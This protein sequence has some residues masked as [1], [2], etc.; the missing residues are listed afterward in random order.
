[1]DCDQVRNLLDAYVDDEL[2][3]ATS[4]EIERHLDDCAGC[5]ERL[6]N[7]RALKQ[8]LQAD[9]LYYRAPDA[10][11][12]RVQ[13]ALPGTPASR[14]TG[15]TDRLRQNVWVSMA[16]ALI[17]GVLLSTALF[18]TPLLRISPSNGLAQ[19]VVDSHIRSLMANHLSDVVSTDQ[20]TVKPWFDGK[21]DFSPT[22]INLEAQGFPLIGG[23]LD[24]LD[25]RPVTA[26]VYQRQKHIINLFI[27]PEANASA[28]AS[29]PL[30][31]QGYHAISWI[32]DGTIYWAVSD[33]ELGE[34]QMF[35][36]LIRAQLPPS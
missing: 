18:Q 30:T 4:L 28:A 25:D 5:A 19:E 6:Q 10:L 12:Q 17:L 24:Y 36:Q 23:R 33:L 8:G 3:P 2:D 35:V 7:R 1:M 11:R 21:L 32:N 16:A 20:H 13:S 34:L 9:A 27:W 15:W 26:L 14:R 31:I 29:A 22:V